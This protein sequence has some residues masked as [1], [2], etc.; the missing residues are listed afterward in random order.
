STFGLALTLVSASRLARL[1]GAARW[2][3]WSAALLAAAT[4]VFGG[5]PFEVRPDML[6]VGLQTTGVL[7]LLAALV[8]DRPRHAA[9]LPPFA[10][11]ALAV[12][13]KQQFLVTPAMG[14][15][16]ILAAW[17]NGRVNARAIARVLLASAAIVLVCY[18]LEEWAT[19]GRMS[20]S[21]FVAA[22][23]VARVHPAD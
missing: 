17:A 8:E 15:V 23:S 10:W 7:I 21:V 3:G 22:S 4:P 9:L 5:L 11:F 14:T 20:R 18:G 6:G 2:A 13:V 16:L 12:C 19:G 1:G